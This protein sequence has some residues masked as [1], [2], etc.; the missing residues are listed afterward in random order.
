MLTTAVKSNFG[1]PQGMLGSITGQ[2]MARMNQGRINWAVSLLK[3][4]PG[5]RILEIGFGPG[6][7]IQQIAE[8]TNA[9]LIAGVDVSDIMMKQASKRN[10]AAI[11]E[12]RVEL[13][14]GS[15][16]DLPYP[17]D[18]FD[19]AFAINSMHHWPDQAQGAAEMRRV[20]KPGGQ[21][22]IAVQP[23]WLADA[24]AKQVHL[25]GESLAARLH[26]AGLKQIEMFLKEMEPVA[27][28]CVIGV[29]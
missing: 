12:G 29:K 25:Y 28:L 4:K 19:R 10:T 1:N 20:L 13:Q 17:D 16:L 18:Q 2:L 8:H 5:E 26:K 3:V 22:L 9:G 27:C 15:A 24:P 11:R 7:A 23:R 14:Y 6:V 21:V